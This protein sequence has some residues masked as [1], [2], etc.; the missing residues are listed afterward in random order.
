MFKETATK[1]ILDKGAL[2]A[3]S[4]AL[5]HLSGA[6]KKIEKRSLIT[7]SKGYVTLQL[8]SKDGMVELTDVLNILSRITPNF[9]DKPIKNITFNKDAKG[10]VFDI[11]EEI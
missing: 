11:P 6:T 5:A 2:Q 1:L 9:E 8:T 7:G 4:L 3:V 10:C